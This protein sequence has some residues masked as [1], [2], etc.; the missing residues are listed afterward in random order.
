MPRL[1]APRRALSSA[2]RSR[3]RRH[4]SRQR[5]QAAQRRRRRRKRRPGDPRMQPAAG[6]GSPRRQR[7]CA[8][9]S[10]WRPPAGGEQPGGL[11]RAQARPRACARRAWCRKFLQEQA[12]SRLRRAQRAVPTCCCKSKKSWPSRCSQGVG[13]AGIYGRE[14]AGRARRARSE[15]AH[16]EAHFL[17]RK[18]FGE[19]LSALA[20]HLSRASSL[21]SSALSSRTLHLFSS[22]NALT[23]HVPHSCHRRRAAQCV[24]KRSGRSA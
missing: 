5:R 11:T 4:A 2:P 16:T 12:G 10:P 18:A 8:A 1:T 15:H 19:F 3:W 24:T 22:S 21:A 7:L 20:F 13:R 17:P 6:N 9:A 14:P 23:I